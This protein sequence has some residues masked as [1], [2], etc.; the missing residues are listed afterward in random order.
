MFSRIKSSR[1]VRVVVLASLWLALGSAPLDRVVA[2]GGATAEAI[3]VPDGSP[4]ELLKFIAE[5]KSRKPAADDTAS[6]GAHFTAVQDAVIGAADKIVA[7][8]PNDQERTAA[9]SEKLSALMLLRR[10]DAPA[11]DERLQ[12]YLDEVARD[13]H[14]S[15]PPL[16]KIFSLASRLQHLDRGNHAEVEKLVADVREHVRS[17]NLDVRNLSVAFQTA[18]AAE[19]AGLTKLAA[20][21]YLDFAAVFAK[22]ENPAVVEN[23][24]KMEGSARLLSLAG[25]PLELEGTLLDGKKFD[26]KSYRGRTVLVVFWATWCGPCV[27]ELPTLKDAYIKYKDRQFAIVTISLDEDRRRL[28]DFV[29]RE[30]DDFAKQ[31]LLAW[32]VIV[33]DNLGGQG[34][35]HPLAK[36]YGVMSLPRTLLVDDQGNVV[37]IDA[38]GEALWELLAK[39]IGPAVVKPK[40]PAAQVEIID[41]AK[42]PEPKPEPKPV[43]KPEPK[44]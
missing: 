41:N 43:P 38:H 10:L 35:N 14:P 44:P 17:S 32:P 18:L 25:Q 34:W 11:A 1:W 30:F 19:Q 20:E 2:A 15:V 29:K 36:H 28:E 27:A 22:S 12:A 24:K 42:K 13:K 16:G 37:T 26:W 39:Q 8:S 9:V 33:G 31:D 6:V 7:G 21:A 3:K 5:V 40:P 23:A 4:A